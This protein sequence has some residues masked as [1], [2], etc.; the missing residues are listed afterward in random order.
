MDASFL[1]FSQ[2]FD[3]VLHSKRLLKPNS[4]LGNEQIITRFA[5]YLHDKF[6]FVHVKENRFDATP[7]TLMY[8]GALV[9]SFIH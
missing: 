2:T 3:R 8:L 9:N 5:N 6:Q 7:S 1:D 4:I